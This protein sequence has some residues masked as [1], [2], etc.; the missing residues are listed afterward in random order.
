MNVPEVRTGRLDVFLL[1]R[2]AGS[3]DYVSRQNEMHF[4]YDPAYIAA[5]DAIPLSQ[6]LPLGTE[7]FDTDK[8]TVFF[9][10]LL[11]PDAVAFRRWRPKSACAR[12]WSLR[13]STG[14]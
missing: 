1:N 3:L 12:L 11:P 6:S 10:N 2:R 9:E 14:L 5:P 8:T 13:D 4:R 7:P